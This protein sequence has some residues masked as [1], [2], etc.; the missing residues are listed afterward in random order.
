MRVIGNIPHPRCNI[1]FFHWNNRYLIK[2]ESGPF[3][4]TYKV[5]EFDLANEEDLKKIVSEEFIDRCM[6]Q[7][8]AMAASLRKSI[9]NI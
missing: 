4:Q 2:V 3:E 8:E 9:E 5:Q 7:F 1:S 6:T